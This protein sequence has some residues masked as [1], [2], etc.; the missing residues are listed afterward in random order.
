VSLSF[1]IFLLVDDGR[2]ITLGPRLSMKENS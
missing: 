1:R 2:S